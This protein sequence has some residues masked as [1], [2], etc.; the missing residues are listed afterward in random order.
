M[1]KLLLNYTLPVLA[2][3]ALTA[4]SSNDSTSDGGQTPVAPT[5]PNAGKELIDFTRDGS[6]ISR[7]GFTRAGFSADTK[8]YMRIKAT[9]DGG[10]GVRYA[11]AEAT[12]GPEVTANHDTNHSPLNMP[13]SDLTYNTGWE[14]YWDDAF[15]RKSKLTVWAFAIPD[16]TDAPL[17]TWDKS[18]WTVVDATT[19][20]NWYTDTEAN[21]TVTWSVS[22]VQTATTMGN[23]DL[24]FS[25]NISS[26]GTGGRYTHTYNSGTSTW[27]LNNTMGDGEM[28][29]VP[30]DNTTGQTTG[31]FDQGHLIFNHALAKVEI[32]LKEGSGFDNAATTDFKWTNPTTQSISLKNLNTSGTFNVSD[33]K[34][35]SQTSSAITTLVENAETTIGT[36]QTTR[37]LTAYIVPGNDLYNGVQ[38][39]QNVIEFEIDNA[40]YYVSGKQIADAIR[41]Y[42]TTNSGLANATTYQS[43]TT[44]TRGHHYII[45]LTVGKKAIERITAAILPWETI[46]SDEIDARNTYPRFTFEDN[47]RGTR[48]QED[49]GGYQFNIYR[50]AQ[51]ASD[52]ITGLEQKNFNWKSGYGNTPAS[53]SW[54]SSQNDWNATDWYWPDN[55][56]Y[57]H[58]RAAGIA[59]H[60]GG[61]PS[62]TVN[63]AENDNF[64]ITH[65][66][67]SE[68]SYKDYIWGAPFN[69]I[70]SGNKFT[71]NPTVDGFDNHTGTDDNAGHQIS[72]AIGSTEDNIHMLLFHMTSQVFVNVTT[73]K[74]A[75]KVI[76]RTNEGTAESDKT[77]VEILN[78][79]PNGTV[80]MGN[81][82]VTATDG[83]RTETQQISYGE[84]TAEGENAAKVNGFSWGVVPQALSVGGQ[85]VGLRVT[86]PDGNRYLIRDISALTATVTTTGSGTANIANP[87]SESS[88]SGHYIINRW[89]PNFKYTYNITIT[90]KGIERITAAVVDWETVTGDNINI[91]L[92]N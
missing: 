80:L 60:T 76:L 48:L 58:F 92:E 27:S 5:D 91:D 1:K 7:A 36:G 32:N 37:H 85:T 43:F 74:T 68:S 2:F 6:G 55:K 34:W 9:E 41:S 72:Q 79:L 30:K 19:N 38:A 50:A 88:T 78:F 69:V 20:K 45:N 89:Y 26:V 71:Y 59:G 46:N 51:T 24:T 53:K 57:Y 63:T 86:T 15:G 44:T 23:E 39:T 56:T 33:G 35:S 16:K 31:K 65:G 11:D 54:D 8:V 47:S 10:S 84:Y 40:Q 18:D 70:G 66:A 62:I 4:C 49:A 90:K 87:Y 83:A 28:V 17:P 42:Y 75:D 52:Y 25:N 21:V 12:A 77:K 81:G 14:R 13:H 82:L 22:T 61:V 64:A 73:T 67:I 29:W 3:C